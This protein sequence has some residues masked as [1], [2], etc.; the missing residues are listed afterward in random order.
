MA[1]ETTDFGKLWHDP[2]RIFA[3][4]RRE[5]PIPFVP[6]ARYF[7]VAKYKDTQG[8]GRKPVVFRTS[9][10][11][12]LVHRVMGQSFMRP[13]SYSPSHK[14]VRIAAR[15]AGALEVPLVYATRKW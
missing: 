6:A 12:S 3:C 1:E 9:K 8:I 2:Y 13:D 10:P 14:D 15:L 7:F 11:R 5:K 4:L